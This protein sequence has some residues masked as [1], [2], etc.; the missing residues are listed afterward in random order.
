MHDKD[1]DDALLDTDTTLATLDTEITATNRRRIKTDTSA[2]HDL[3][4]IPR[5]ASIGDY[6]VGR[7]IGGGDSGSVYVARHNESSGRA[8]LKVLYQDR[9]VS[10]RQVQWFT[11][12]LETLAGLE[13]P[14]V[15]K[16]YDIGQLADGRPYYVT[17]L[18]TGVSLGET[19][20]IHGR[21]EPLAALDIFDPICYAL[22]AAHQAG[23][24]H[25]NLKAN[26]IMVVDE[27]D[28]SLVKVLDFALS[29]LSL[30]AGGAGTEDFLF[31]GAPDAAAP[32]QL[33]GHAAT[34]RSD[35]YA[36]GALLFKTLTGDY[37]FGGHDEQTIIQGHLTIAAPLP[38]QLAPLAPAIDS[39]IL[40][41][42]EKDPNRRFESVLSLQN[43]LHRALGAARQS[44]REM[45]RSVVIYIRVQA[46]QAQGDETVHNEV[47]REVMMFLDNTE[48]NLREAGFAIASNVTDGIMGVTPLPAEPGAAVQVREHALQTACGMYRELEDRTITASQIILVSVALRI[49]SRLSGATTG[50]IE[51]PG[52]V[53]K[54]LHI[55]GPGK[56]GIYAMPEMFRDLMPSL[57]EATEA[58][59]YVELDHNT[60][61]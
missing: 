43:A 44:A 8:A 9:A 35:I 15:I 58:S 2:L 19:L 18:L 33:Q 41:C 23:V 4:R 57:P 45:P 42:L 22:Q 16:L 3:N 1:D 13:H 12:E 17:E 46:A 25:G 14:N 55:W 5:G 30:V 47:L 60:W 54:E 32:E 37:P 26:N 7:R 51:I 39:L 24:I 21:L 11:Q 29:R 36:L 53:L 59:G 31:L 40:R 38:S 61:L 28:Q 20:N 52:D 48:D 34:V 50:E 49:D 56:T 10:P 27:R 6:V